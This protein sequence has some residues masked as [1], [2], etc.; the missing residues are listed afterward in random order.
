MNG[1]EVR[2]EAGSIEAGLANGEKLLAENPSAAALQAQTL[3]RA[4]PRN[5]AAHRLLAKA[6]GKLGDDAQAK[7]ARALAVQF[8]RDEQHVVRAHQAVLGGRAEEALALLDNHLTQY[9]DDPV[10]LLVHGEALARIGRMSDAITDF[11]AA[12]AFMPEYREARLALVRVH[13]QRFDPRAALAALAPLLA[14]NPED[15]ALLRWQAAMFSECGDHVKA[16]TVL[17]K[18]LARQPGDPALLISHGDMLRILGRTD[19]AERLY[20]QAIAVAPGMGAAWWSLASL[21][22]GARITADDRTALQAALNAP[23][24]ADDHLYLA[25][26]EAI[27]ADRAGEHECAFALF[28]EANRLRREQLRYDSAAF[29]QRMVAL[30]EAFDRGFFET[31][32]GWGAQSN[33]PIFIVG[34]ARSGSTLV[35]QILA[36]HSAIAAGGEMP[37]VTSLLRETAARMR[38]DPDNEI[39]ELLRTLTPDDC[40]ALGTEYLR[41]A[42]D[43]CGNDTPFFTDKMPHNW[44]EIAFIRLILPQAGIVDVR[45][46]ALDCCV[47]NFTMLFQPGHPASYDLDEIADYYAIYV[48]AMAWV[49]RVL[50]GSIHLLRYEA[51]IDDP[52]SQTRSLLAY[53]GL[54]YEPSCLALGEGSR[55]IATASAEQARQPINRRGIG[56]WKRFEPWLSSLKDGL[57]PLADD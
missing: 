33:A 26:A 28:S 22:S 17:K 46:G 40:T 7:R 52:E 18:A 45:R 47:S 14:T 20:R 38:L 8:T 21:D 25:F 56:G 32:S 23:R 51:L 54:E 24:S 36:G 44:A 5:A 37:L 6:L 27:A 57:G 12:L 34:M 48:K 1:R 39:V 16:E 53:T 49:D 4:A 10:A 13:Y 2:Y 29:A 43:R 9:P 30:E 19:S 35:E 15:V 55:V 31:R 3:I 11:E 50:P 42:R 41:R